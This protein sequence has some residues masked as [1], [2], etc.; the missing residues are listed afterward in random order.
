VGGISRRP[1]SDLPLLRLVGLFGITLSQIG[2]V[3]ALS[4]T[5]ASDTALL[6]ATVPIMTTPWGTNLTIAPTVCLSGKRGQREV[7]GMDVRR[8]PMRVLIG[9]DGSELADRVCELVAS[10]DWPPGSGL[11]VVTAYPPNLPG[12]DWPGGGV[13]PV[14]A[15]RVF[16]AE[17]SAAADRAKAAADRIRR[18]DVTVTWGSLMGRAASV[19]LDEASAQSTDLLIVGNRGLG[20]FT[21]ALVGS[22]S[23]EVIDGAGCPVLLVRRPAIDRVLLA[24]DGSEGATAAAAVLAWPIFARSQVRIVTVSESGAHATE[25]TSARNAAERPTA[26]GRAHEIDARSG[27][28]AHEIVQAASEWNAD[29]IIIGSRGRT[30]LARLL[31]GSVARKVVTHAPCS[32][33]IKRL[34]A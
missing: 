31:L 30:G 5:S 23:A 21:S 22:V 15:Q 4:D 34:P 17:R 33:L 9:Y 10:I 32:V 28:P 29:L 25:V 8:E 14:V 11:R 7:I 26:V 1:S 13:E 20:P 12:E 3:F 16:E 6:G 19:L 24:D 27:D 18:P 2:F